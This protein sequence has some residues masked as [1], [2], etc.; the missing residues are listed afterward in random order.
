MEHLKRD[1][2]GRGSSLP[3]FSKYTLGFADNSHHFD[4]SQERRSTWTKGGAAPL[5]PLKSRGKE[6]QTYPSTDRIVSHFLP[7]F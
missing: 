6:G 2:K 7:A 3:A 5:L 1:I 4:D